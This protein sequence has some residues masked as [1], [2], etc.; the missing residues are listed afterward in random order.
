MNYTVMPGLKNRKRLKLNGSHVIETALIYFE[1]TDVELKGKK[2]T[3]HFAMA[4]HIIC[5]LLR[6]EYGMTLKEIG[7]L[8][9]RDHTSV[10]HGVKTVSDLL[11]TKNIEMVKAVESVKAL[12]K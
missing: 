8:L 1:M 3:R 11:H 4:R 2:R 5:H 6:Y 9:N 12:L 10:M 7:L